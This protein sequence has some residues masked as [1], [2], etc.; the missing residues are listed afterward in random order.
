M[1]RQFVLKSFVIYL[2]FLF[3][4]MQLKL[5]NFVIFFLSFSYAQDCT[6]YALNDCHLGEDAEFISLNAGSQLKCQ[7][8]CEIQEECLFYSY[9]KRPTQNVDCHLYTVPFHVY[10]NQCDVRTGPLNQNPPGKCLTPEENSCE[11]EQHENCIL[12]GERLESG[13]TAPDVVTCEAFCQINQG[14]GCKY[15]EW[16]REKKTCNLYDSAEKQCNIAFGPS[17][18]APGECGTTQKPDETTIGST[19]SPNYCDL[20]CPEK[21]LEQFEDCNNCG[22]YV[23]CY[24][25]VMTIKT[26]PNCYLFDG[27][28][29]YCNQPTQVAC[30]D[31]PEDENC[32]AATKPGDCPFDNG[33]FKDAHNCRNYFICKNGHPESMSCKNGT[34]DGLYD[35][36][37]EW[38]NWQD[39]VDC[40]DRPICTGDY[41]EYNNCQCQ[42]AETVDNF[43][44]PNSPNVE[45]FI[46]PYNCQHIIVCQ[47]GSQDDYYCESNQFGDDQTGTC[48]DDPS[49]CRGKPICN[50]IQDSTDCYCN[51][52]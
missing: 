12:Y 18:G 14:E 17:D 41:P 43:Q 5:W 4:K 35:Y 51:N 31:R 34:F 25:G 47:A 30:G 37:L 8:H 39:K 9:H 6:D 3:A 45:V 38:C 10:A 27:A 52:N 48:K 24:N 1:G 36:N 15:W 2:S 7:L 20:T 16:S 40:E 26:C 33:Y 32:S 13:L 11:I 49:V 44:C 50:N 23:E 21:G 22:G 42:G 46:D 29:G 19:A 28:K